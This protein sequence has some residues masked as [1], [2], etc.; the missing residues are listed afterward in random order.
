[1]FNDFTKKHP[2]LTK[3]IRNSIW[4]IS[5]F[6]GFKIISSPIVGLQSTIHVDLDDDSVSK[7]IFFGSYERETIA[8]IRK[9]A[10][11]GDIIFDVGANIGYF[12]IIFSE[13]VRNEGMVHSFEPSRREY[14]KLC[15][16]ISRNNL[17]NVFMNN[18]ALGENDSYTQM[19]IFDDSKYGA[20]NTLGEVSHKKVLRSSYHSELIR[21]MRGDTYLS[22]F[23]GSDP[24]LLKIDVEG[25]ESEVI[26]GMSDLLQKDNGP[27]LIVEICQG[28]HQ[29]D[30][31]KIASLI[32]SITSYGYELFQPD[33]AGNLVPF[34]LNASLNCV[35]IKPTYHTNYMKERGISINHG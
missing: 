10:K 21:I 2:W 17:Y 7:P 25:Y 18:L 34:T 1:M 29:N 3:K 16:N 28:T 32:N 24:N 31:D 4:N 8:F 26:S 11:P 20:Y 5:C 22:L 33:K 30:V 6:S 19:S 23:P 27:C 9:F 12:S 35:A 14:F 15:K 13:L